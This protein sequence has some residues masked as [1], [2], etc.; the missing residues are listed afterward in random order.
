M[1]QK[2]IEVETRFH[3]DNP[4]EAYA[5]IPFLK[6]SLTVTNNWETWHY[7]LDLFKADQIIRIGK[8][9]KDDN[10]P[11]FYLGWKGANHGEI[12][13]I[14]E[15][16][17]EEITD[18]IKESA[19]LSLLGCNSEQDS[20]EDVIKILNQLGHQPFM[21]FSGCNQSGYYQPLDLHLKLMKCATLRWPLL[22]EIEQTAHNFDEATQKEANLLQIIENFGLRNRLVQDEPPTLLYQTLTQSI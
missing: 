10:F 8:N 3:F 18:G 16:M 5:L 7:G 17:D 13:N 21:S 9:V 20:V 2:S 22:V 1:I 11:R 19:I 12:I 15:E 4:E 14:R 6:D